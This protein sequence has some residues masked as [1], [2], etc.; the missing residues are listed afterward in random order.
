MKL[1]LKLLFY[2]IFNILIIHVLTQK[3]GPSLR[4]NENLSVDFQKNG[5][6]TLSSL[7]R[8]QIIFNCSDFKKD[9]EIYFKITAEKFKDEYISFEFLDN[10]NG[11]FSYLHRQKSLYSTDKDETLT[12]EIRYYT[13]K[14]SSEN[15][16]RLQGKYL[17][18]KLNCEGD[19]EIENIESLENIK[20]SNIK[21]ILAT[22]ISVI[23]VIVIIVALIIYCCKRKRNAQNN[24]NN[25][26]YTT[27]ISQN[28]M[29]NNTNYNQQNQIN[30]VQIPQ[31]QQN[32]QRRREPQI[33]IN[34]NTNIHLNIENGNS[35]TNRAFTY[36]RNQ[37]NNNERNR[38]NNRNAGSS[39]VPRIYNN[40]NNGYSNNGFH[41]DHNSN[42]RND[43]PN[44]DNHFNKPQQNTN[45]TSNIDNNNKNTPQND[46]TNIDYPSINE[47]YQNNNNVP[48]NEQNLNTSQTSQ[49][50]GAPN[51]AHFPNQTP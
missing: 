40:N 44:K 20:K 6:I 30:Q 42:N 29:Y 45:N 14:K 13:I 39:N 10:L 7:Y 8:E 33:I 16:G 22:I 17:L 5:K 9:E 23:I 43:Q 35:N 12:K 41:S 47:I 25:T 18:I 38:R 48:R 50:L 26:P 1:N 11:Y 49:N 15:L 19:V 31:N 3:K 32:L 27:T 36:S 24:N 37:Y 28:N 51:A 21:E 4:R 34:Q 46:N 2:L